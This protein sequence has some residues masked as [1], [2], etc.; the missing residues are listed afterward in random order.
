MGQSLR[1]V[2]CSC[3]APALLWQEGRGSELLQVYDATFASPSKPTEASGIMSGYN[4]LGALPYIAIAMR[5]AGRDAE[6][7]ALL[8]AAR[9]SI[10]AGNSDMLRVD[11]QVALAR[12]NAL[13]GKREG[14]LDNLLQARP[15]GWPGT[16][17]LF[18]SISIIPIENDPAFVA[19][20]GLPEFVS[21]AQEISRETARERAEYSASAGR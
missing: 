2:E 11:R 21:L 18:A 20:R 13:L 1:C 15:N 7:D 8:N 19:L 6:A 17:P 14:A 12:G 4:T 9:S 16:M 3:S 5:D 10:T